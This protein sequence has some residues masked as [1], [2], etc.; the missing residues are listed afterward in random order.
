[1]VADNVKVPGAPKYR[2]YM[3]RH[4]GTSWRTVEHET[5]VE[6]QTLLRDLVLE[7]EY[8]GTPASAEGNSGGTTARL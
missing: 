8:L 1:V 7:S 5:H 2:A 6:Y 3:Q 4:D